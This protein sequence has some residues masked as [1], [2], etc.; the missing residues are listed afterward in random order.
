M[1]KLHFNS[2]SI[3][4]FKT[5]TKEKLI[6]MPS[7]FHYTSSNAF[8]SIIK[9]GKIRFTDIRFLNDKSESIYFA[10]VLLDYLE[11]HKNN[12]P[13]SSDA[14][15][16]LLKENDINAIRNLEVTEVK[17][18]EYE[19]LPY[20][21]DRRFIFCAS[22]KS[23]QL[24]MWN[25]YVNNG[26]YEGYSIGIDILEL[27][28]TFDTEEE[29]LSDPFLVYYGNVLYHGKSQEKE[30]K[31]LLD[32]IEVFISNDSK[33]KEY[34]MITLRNYINTRG[35]FYKDK[36][37]SKEDEFRVVITI[38]EERLHSDKS[39]YGGI[40]NKE[41]SLDFCVKNG[42]IVPFLE[43]TIPKKAIK[44]VVVSPI[45]EYDIAK[46]SAKE[47]LKVKGFNEVKI[48]KSNI[49]IRF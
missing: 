34:A 9:N 28:K 4:E 24:N 45:V 15:Y 20:K 42:L 36:S 27:L 2:F 41:L 25:Y 12:Y 44:R 7:K 38:S 37:F 22:N 49:P 29:K 21:E 31:E 11:K 8:L 10:K 23:D 47:L 19:G 18:R 33:N 32:K 35:V 43:V 14:I 1:D 6:E 3:Q 46:K 17:Y 26:R 48:Y 13:S 30:I 39:H 16:D 5:S 40:N